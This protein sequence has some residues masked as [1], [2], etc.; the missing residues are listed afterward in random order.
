MNGLFSRIA[1]LAL[2]SIAAL[3]SSHAAAIPAITFPTPQTFSGPGVT[4]TRGF[5]FDVLPAEGV[6]VTDLSI[7]DAA[8]NGLAVSHAVGIW[9]AA[10]VL[11][12][13]TTVPAGTVAPLDTSGLFRVVN[14]PDVFLPQGAGYVVGGEFAPGPIGD[15]LVTQWTTA[16]TAPQIAYRRS[17]FVDNG[18]ATLTFPTSSLPGSQGIVG[19]SFQVVPAPEP[20][21]FGLITVASALGSIMRWPRASRFPGA[22][23]T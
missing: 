20:S 7:L 1:L 23:V 17:R 15:P 12:A 9:D 19:P 13:F 5:E 22:P 3:R 18:S 21:S 14:I 2:F 11:L 4:S 8:A 10:G 6:F 16:T